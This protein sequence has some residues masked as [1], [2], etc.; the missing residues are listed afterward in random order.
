MEA[1]SA[2]HRVYRVCLFYNAHMEQSTRTRFSDDLL[3]EDHPL[4]RLVRADGGR[5]PARLNIVLRGLV[6]FG[7][8]FGVLVV[9]GI[10]GGIVYGMAAI[11]AGSTAPGMGFDVD[12]PQVMLGA[13]LLETVAAVT[14]YVVV[15]FCMERRRHPLEFRFSRCGGLLVGFVIGFGAIASSLGVL[16]LTGGYR[17]A[18]FN[19]HY[20]PLVDL[21]ALGMCA[22]VS[23]EIMMR[24]MLLRLIEEWLGSWGGVAVSALVFG[25]LHVSNPDGTLWGGLAIAIED[26]ILA[27]ALYVITRSLWVVIGEHMMWNFAEGPI[28]GSIVSGTG[29]Q[30]SWLVAQW[31]GP[32]W[33]TGGSFGLEASVV[34]VILM[35]VAGVALLVYAQ[36]KGMMVKPSWLRRRAIASRADDSP[37][38]DE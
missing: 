31:R 7:T 14:G 21:V 38:V 2:A 35:G 12:D 18:G 4:R 1:P 22:G 23:K 11:D 36:R 33:L 15:V 25:L 28:F 17:I 30:D 20:N 26:G 27:A 9:L 32:D 3:T 34:P 19:V 13:M 5:E 8:F 16:A 10:I 6:F 24:G 29:K 37:S